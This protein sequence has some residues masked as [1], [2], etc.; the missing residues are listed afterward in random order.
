M[1][2][3]YFVCLPLALGGVSTAHLAEVAA[4]GRA[5]RRPPASPP[6]A[7]SSAFMGLATEWKIGSAGH[8]SLNELQ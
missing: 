2:L 7:T 8:V 3:S 5:D 4:Q 1:R 6:T